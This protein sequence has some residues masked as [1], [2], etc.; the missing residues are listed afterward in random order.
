MDF[1]RVHWRQDYMLTSPIELNGGLHPETPHLRVGESSLE[2]ERG[3]VE[4]DDRRRNGEYMRKKMTGGGKEVP[5]T[6]CWRGGSSMEE[7]RGQ[8]HGKKMTIGAHRPCA[9]Q[10]CKRDPDLQRNF[11]DRGMGNMK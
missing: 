8:G 5:K 11:W 9:L 4:E 10:R 1:V 6:Q 7:E 2:E 3:R